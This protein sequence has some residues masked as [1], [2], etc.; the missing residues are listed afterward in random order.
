M[1]GGD[2]AD[3][4]KE[5]R[6]R[7][8]NKTWVHSLKNIVHQHFLFGKKVGKLENKGTFYTLEKKK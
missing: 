4:S 3:R 2:G 6:L 5:K 7:I 8:Q 1:G